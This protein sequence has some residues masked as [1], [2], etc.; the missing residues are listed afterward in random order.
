[1]QT[2]LK[3]DISKLQKNILAPIIE[4]LVKKYNNYA[5]SLGYN[6]IWEGTSVEHSISRSDLESKFDI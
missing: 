2:Q 5:K 4:K 6:N 3:N 1:M